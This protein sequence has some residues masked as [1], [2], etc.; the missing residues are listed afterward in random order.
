MQ[1]FITGRFPDRVGDGTLDRNVENA[2]V[3]APELEFDF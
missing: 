2:P 3:A 1:K